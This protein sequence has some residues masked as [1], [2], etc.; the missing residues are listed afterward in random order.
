MSTDLEIARLIKMK[1][2]WEIGKMI[3]IDKDDLEMYGDFKAKVTLD[4]IRRM[5]DQDKGNLVL[6]SAI[7][8]TPAG[9]GKTTVAI[10]LS[11]ALNKL[12]NKT[13]VTLREPSL[14]P[15]FGMKGGATGGGRAQVLPMDDI[16]LHFTGDIHAVTTAHN[17]IAAVIENHIFRRKEP[18]LDI[19][20]VEWSRVLDI[21]DRSLRDMVIGLGGRKH[22]FPRE[23]FFQIS[24]SSEIMAI[25]CLAE[26][27]ADLK[28]RVSNIFIGCSCSGDP[29]YL[30][31]LKVAGAAAALLK[32]ALRPNLVQTTEA[33]P[34][35]VHGGPFANIA[36]GTCSVISMKLALSLADFVVTEAGFGF[37]LGAEK[38][39]D[40]VARKAGLNPKAV[41]LVATVRALKMHGGKSLK[42]LNRPDP[43]SV[44]QG[45]TNLGK[46]LENIAKFKIPPVVAINKFADDT[47]EE[48]AL[49]KAFTKARGVEA[50]VADV[51]KKGGEGALGL[52]EI[53]ARLAEHDNRFQ[54][55]YSL[56]LPVDEKIMTVA[57]EIYGAEAIDLKKKA[58]QDLKMIKDLGLEQLPVCIAKT[59]RSLSDNPK[60][61]GRPKD[62]LVTVRE[63]RISSGAGF[64]VPIT[65]N[66]L[67]MPGLPREPVAETVDIDDD[68]KITGLF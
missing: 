33:T 21:N 17:L 62:F 67:Q 4:L 14:G 43:E 9:E 41:V 2:I 68:G 35:F 47:D 29:V 55:L 65:G 1:P 32:D 63:I 11:L 18:D 66:V 12:G 24:A 40:I 23:S 22:G 53:V 7:T 5:A 36:Q 6:V 15:L 16:N 52:A 37:D 45:L 38:F 28:R 8:P 57:S 27:F 59:H 50:V 46:H 31:D 49:I 10:G 58:K 26:S 48:I 34:A 30:R 51:H 3:G 20:Q 39:F 13:I 19:R 25:L 54:P 44:S 56:D 42:E 61:L 60:L 64:L